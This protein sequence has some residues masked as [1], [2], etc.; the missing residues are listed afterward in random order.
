[1]ISKVISISEKVNELPDIF[2]MLLFTWMIPHTD[3]FGRLGGSPGKV[4]GLIVPMLDKTK[5]EIAESLQRLKNHGLIHWY[6]VDGEQF[7]QII[8]FEKHQQ[9]LH[10]RTNSK[11][12]EFPGISGNVQEIPSELNRT[13]LNRTEENRREEEQERNRI[14]PA[15]EPSLNNAEDEYLFDGG[16]LPTVSD[17]YRMFEAEGF[18]TISDVIKDQIND[19]IKDYSERWLCEAMK[20]AILA[21]KRS[22]NY[23]GGTLKNWKA[24]GIDEPWTKEK[25][26]RSNTSSNGYRNG[27]GG[28]SGKPQ[29]EI[30]KNPVAPPTQEEIELHEKSMAELLEKRKRAEEEKGR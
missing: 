12:P 20:K 29:I 15:V 13:E 23:V 6:E 16:P 30:T 2:D 26:I 28:Q 11:F 27:R 5:Q 10:K 8:Q 17:A 3:D 9:G 19:F 25:D 18:G 4:K 7:V 1:M 24:E 21:G 22:L 14:E